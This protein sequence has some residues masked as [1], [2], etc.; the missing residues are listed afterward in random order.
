LG[1]KKNYE[2]VTPP[3]I[4]SIDGLL[5]KHNFQLKKHNYW[6]WILKQPIMPPENCLLKNNDFIG[7]DIS[8]KLMDAEEECYSECQ[9]MLECKCFTFVSAHRTCYL[10]GPNCILTDKNTVGMISG[11][12]DCSSHLVD[13]CFWYH[14]DYSG[15]DIGDGIVNVPSYQDC[16]YHCKSIQNC[17]CW[18]LDIDRNI[19]WLKSNCGNNSTKL[20]IIS[21][22]RDCNLIN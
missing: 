17:K 10:K 7:N 1:R 21:G 18:S 22:P 8:S 13:N 16:Q 9:D 2:Q 20:H 4:E 3:T 5:T 11:W 12:R 14:L 6:G 15:S 19:C